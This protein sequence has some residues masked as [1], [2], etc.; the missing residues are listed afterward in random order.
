[1]SESNIIVIGARLTRYRALICRTEEYWF[2]ECARAY[3]YLEWQ[4]TT[5]TTFIVSN[6][7]SQHQSAPLLLRRREYLVESDSLT[8]T[9]ACAR[10]AVENRQPFIEPAPRTLNAPT[11]PPDQLSPFSTF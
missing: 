6:A 7:R 11:H 9:R 8:H 1:M 2:T 4:R 5:M 10:R 3:P